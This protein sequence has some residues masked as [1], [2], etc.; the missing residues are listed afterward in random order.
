MGGRI[1]DDEVITHDARAA[2]PRPEVRMT[3]GTGGRRRSQGQV[4][5]RSERPDDGLVGCD[6][7]GDSRSGAGIDAQLRARRSGELNG[8]RT[9]PSK[10]IGWS[11]GQVG[12]CCRDVRDLLIVK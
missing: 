1:R 8:S 7:T 12:R 6:R 10:S 5:R 2:R 11:H 9:Y 3:A 4:P